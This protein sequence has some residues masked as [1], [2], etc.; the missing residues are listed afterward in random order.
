MKWAFTTRFWCKLLYKLRKACR[1]QNLQ[2]HRRS[3]S[4]KMTAAAILFIVMNA[5]KWAI[6]TR[7]WWNLIH[8][9]ELDVG[10]VD[11]W[12]G[13]G[14]VGL[15]REFLIIWWV[16]LGWVQFFLRSKMVGTRTWKYWW[17]GLGWKVLN[18]RWVGLGWVQK[19]W[20]G[21][22]WVLKKWPTSNSDTD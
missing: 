18:G 17:V 3:A 6:T 16:G 19:F 22:G 7:S 12:V 9:P 10:W 15:G 4:F 14:W 5:I 1:V 11:P 21:L 2:N 20:V 8:R 13:L